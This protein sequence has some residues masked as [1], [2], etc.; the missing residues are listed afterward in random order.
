MQGTVQGKKVQDEEEKKKKEARVEE[1]KNNDA[2]EKRRSEMFN[3]VRE[4]K[5]QV[6]LIAIN[7][8]EAERE[9]EEKKRFVIRS[10]TFCAIIL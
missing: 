4:T 3:L 9:R 6:N 5:S 10:G 8:W 1:K 2:G 7:E